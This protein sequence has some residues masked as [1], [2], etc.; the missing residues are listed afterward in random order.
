MEHT[1]LRHGP[2][3]STAETWLHSVRSASSALLMAE[4]SGADDAA[5]LKVAFE[6]ELDAHNVADR[7][8]ATSIAVVPDRRPQSVDEVRAWIAGLDRVLDDMVAALQEAAPM[9]TP[10]TEILALIQRLIAAVEDN[11]DASPLTRARAVHEAILGAGAVVQDLYC[12]TN[13]STQRVAPAVEAWVLRTPSDKLLAQAAEQIEKEEEEK[14][15]KKQKEKQEN[16]IEKK[17]NKNN[18]SSTSAGDSDEKKKKKQKDKSDGE[19]AGG[20]DDSASEWHPSRMNYARLAA[21][22][23]EFAEALDA[24]DTARLLAFAALCDHDPAQA[25][26]EFGTLDTFLQENVWRIYRRD[27]DGAREVEAQKEG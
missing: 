13:A 24:E 1:L 19:D 4:S 23:R 17:E 22:A 14:K 8:A 16:E 2:C 20:D 27:D 12:Y 7:N 9:M 26:A 5:E 18:T 25:S 11:R 6:A 3:Q 10:G 21:A 15:K